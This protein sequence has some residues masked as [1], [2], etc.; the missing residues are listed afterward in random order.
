MRALRFSFLLAVGL[1]LGA[2]DSGTDPG[3]DP[4]RTPLA[5][6]AT[7]IF[8]ATSNAFSTPAPNLGA[9]GL[10]KHMAGDAA[11]EAA[12]VAAPAQVNGGLG[13][14]FNNNACVACHPRD[15][16]GRPPLPGEAAQSVFLRISVQGVADDGSGAPAPVPGF[17]TQLFDR[18]LFG[19]TPMGTFGV[20]YV[21][22]QETFADG[23]PYQLRAP[24][25]RI[26]A[27]YQNL[28]ALVFLSPR[29]AP[30][31][32]G[33]GLLEAIEEATILS[34]ADE[35][36]ADGDGISGRPNW[37]WDFARSEV[38]LGRFGLKASNPTVLQQ[39]AGAYRGDIGVTNPYFP[40]ESSHGTSLWDGLDDDPELDAATLDAATFYVQT[41]AVPARRNA[42]SP[43]VRRGERLFASARCTSC[44]LPEVRTG[45]L[46]GVPE[47]SNQLIHPYTDMLLHDMGEGLADGRP[48]FSADGSEWRTAPLW[49]IGLTQ[50]VNGHTLFLHD[51]RARTLMEAVMWHGGEAEFSREAVRHLDA[52]ERRALIAFLETL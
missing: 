47:V 1:A 43:L 33:R 50:V 36:D 3:S 52:T 29:V 16:R 8:D 38:A 28:P 12:F 45:L 13:P 39:V 49:G 10:E 48:D 4:A 14:V 9:E 24:A 5:G 37:V 35:A 23:E 27:P 46:P 34:R 2:C 44:H 18:A 6:G 17:G 26:D 11:F 15:G 30:P 41:L 19:Q 21:E 22:R 51:G 42:N 32:F 7:T 40:V 20:E 25:Y 31:V